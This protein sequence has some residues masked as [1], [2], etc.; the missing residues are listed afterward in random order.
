MYGLLLLYIKCCAGVFGTLG[1]S[2]PDPGSKE[3]ITLEK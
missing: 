2:F 3:K 1:R